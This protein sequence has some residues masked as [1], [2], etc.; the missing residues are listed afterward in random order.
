[1]R[2]QNIK[3]HSPGATQVAEQASEAARRSFKT[4]RLWLNPASH[5]RVAPSFTNLTLKLQTLFGAMLSGVAVSVQL[6]NVLVCL[7]ML[8]VGPS[9]ILSLLH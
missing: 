7:S 2:L 8:L 6:G 1:M 5:P 9:I 3:L 4:L